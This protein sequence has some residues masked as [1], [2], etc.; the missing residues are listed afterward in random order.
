MNQYL[1]D[2]LLSIIVSL[3]SRS[4]FFHLRSNEKGWCNF[5]SQKNNL[6]AYFRRWMNNFANFCCRKFCCIFATRRF[7]ILAALTG[8]QAMQITSIIKKE[9]ILIKFIAAKSFCIFRWNYYDLSFSFEISVFISSSV[10]EN[11]SK[12]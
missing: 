9:A 2:S 3:K 5:C 7:P 12:T 11:F 10:K 4:K 1:C 6:F 8:L